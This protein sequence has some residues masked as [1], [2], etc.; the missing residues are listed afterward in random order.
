MPSEDSRPDVPQHYPFERGRENRRRI[1]AFDDE[2]EEVDEEITTLDKRTKVSKAVLQRIEK[3]M[4]WITNL[5]VG[6]LLALVGIL[7]AG[8][9]TLI[10][11]LA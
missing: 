9:I 8:V 2:L 4:R 1:E 10:A 5:L 7:L 11:N 6:N 3:K